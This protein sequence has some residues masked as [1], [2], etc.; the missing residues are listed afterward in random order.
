M[1][2]KSEVE[3]FSKPYAL[4]VMPARGWFGTEK[5]VIAFRG[6]VTPLVNPPSHD[7]NAVEAQ[8]KALN[9]AFV[10]GRAYQAVLCG[11]AIK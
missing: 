1:V 4:R 2:T 5:Y 10:L 3:T 8:V 9:G 11:E 7:R 6:V